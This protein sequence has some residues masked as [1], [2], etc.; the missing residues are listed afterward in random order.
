[1][2]KA[3]LEEK[4][5]NADYQLEGRDNEIRELENQQK[6]DALQIVALQNEK[7]ELTDRVKELEAQIEKMKAELHHRLI[8]PSHDDSDCLDKKEVD[9]AENHCLFHNDCP[10]QKENAEL[11]VENA[12]CEKACEGATMMYEHLVKAKEII[13]KYMRFKPVVGGVQYYH[14]EYEQTEKEAEQFLSEVEK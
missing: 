6:I 8:S 14:E 4:L 5:A 10:I 7:G 13:K 11:K 9:Y 3:E 1:M 2:I 12:F